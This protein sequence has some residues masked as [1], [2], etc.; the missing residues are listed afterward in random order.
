MII[1]SLRVSLPILQATRPARLFGVRLQLDL[2]QLGP[3]LLRLQPLAHALPLAGL[4][5]GSHWAGAL[6]LMWML[7]RKGRVMF[8]LV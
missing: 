4:Q 2:L 3:Q 1:Y 6:W 8:W 5:L 7:T